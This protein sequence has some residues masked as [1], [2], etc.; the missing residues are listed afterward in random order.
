MLLNLANLPN[1]HLYSLQK[2][3]QVSDLEQ[4]Q[5][6]PEVQDLREHLTS[7][8]ATASLIE[9]LDLVISVDTAVAHLAGA[10]GKQ[11]WLLLPSIPDW[12]WLLDRDD[13]LVS[14]HAFVPP[15]CFWRL[16]QRPKA[17]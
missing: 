16:G 13:T 10:M 14:I 8:V 3:V 6:H 1:V 5:A 17:C 11:T 4:L 12:R 7:F 15:I 2:E 9:P